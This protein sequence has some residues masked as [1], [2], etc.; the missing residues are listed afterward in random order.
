MNSLPPLSHTHFDFSGLS[1]RDK[2]K[3]IIG[4]VIPR[5]IALVT[6]IDENGVVNAAPFSFFNA[7]SGDP[8]IVAIGVENKADMSFKDTGHNIRMTE[9]FT[10]NIVDQAMIDAMNTCAVPFPP[11]VDEVDVAGLTQVP[12]VHVNCPRILEAPAALECKRYITLEIGKSREIIL[13]EVLGVFIRN[14]CVNPLNKH[15]DQKRMDAVGRLGGHDYS[16]IRDQFTL[17]TMSVAEWESRNSNLDDS[18][19]PGKPAG[20]QKQQDDPLSKQQTGGKRPKA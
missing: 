9:Q 4:T 2:Y 3:L 18:K 20:E 19:E 17:P 14:D 7:L 11:D 10:V 1:G 13:G 5:P 8:A 12:G 16:T 15:V 6:T